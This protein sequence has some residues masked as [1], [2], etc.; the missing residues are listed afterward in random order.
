MEGKDL[1]GWWWYSQCCIY[2]GAPENR[3]RSFCMIVCSKQQHSFCL[4]CSQM[5][6]VVSTHHHLHTCRMLECCIHT[7]SIYG[8]DIMVIRHEGLW[9]RNTDLEFTVHSCATRITACSFGV[10]FTHTS[11]PLHV[12]DKHGSCGLNRQPAKH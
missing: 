3:I 6:V 1:G 9:E 4:A 2:T 12:G 5:L 10:K 7:C 11:S 8:W